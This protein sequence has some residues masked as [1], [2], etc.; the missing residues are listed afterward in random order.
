MKILF[1]LTFNFESFFVD[2][3]IEQTRFY[4]WKQLTNSSL[5]SFKTRQITRDSFSRSLSMIQKIFNDL[6]FNIWCTVFS[7][8]CLQKYIRRIF[9]NFVRSE[10][11]FQIFEEQCTFFYFSKYPK[12]KVLNFYFIGFTYLNRI[13]VLFHHLKL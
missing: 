1:F 11:K 6:N 5:S 2:R 7:N 9:W 10:E 12:E 13:I 4:H 8:K 3:A